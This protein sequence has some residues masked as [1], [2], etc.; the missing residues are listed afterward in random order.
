MLF[1]TAVTMMSSGTMLVYHHHMHDC[2]RYRKLP[3]E[4]NPSCWDGIPEADAKSLIQSLL[5]TK[6]QERATA[7]S[8]LASPMLAGMEL[9]S[10][11]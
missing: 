8:L 5:K 9:L 11:Q 1:H 2:C 6:P 3:F 4:A 10:T 7:S